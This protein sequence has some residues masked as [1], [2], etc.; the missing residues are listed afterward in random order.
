[1]LI[2]A[3]VSSIVFSAAQASISAPTD[4]FRG[5]LKSAA[6][7]A[8]DTK[9]AP[10][11]IEGYFK[12]ECSVQMDSLKKAV[13]AFRV[14][15]GMSKKAALEDADMTVDDYVASPADTYRY[16]AERDAKDQ[17]RAAAAATPA[18]PAQPATPSPQSP[19]P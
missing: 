9:V 11:G 18:A 16:F 10:D 12:T 14:K 15:N 1:M 7:K 8:K 17:A 13:I 2:L 19:K 5:C 6:T 3:A 4:A